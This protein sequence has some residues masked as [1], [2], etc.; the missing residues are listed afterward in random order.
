MRTSRRHRGRELALRVLFEIDG[1]DKGVGPAL[2]Y[3][4]R[5]LTSPP[6]VTAF[7]ATLANGWFEHSGTVDAA[8][9]L[10]STNWKLED[11]GKVERAILRLATYELV[12]GDTPAAVA[13][14]EAVE[15]A[16][17]YA[18][19]EASS[20]VNGVLSEVERARH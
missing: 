8:I 20:F 11:L 17:V 10:A 2:E 12:L 9:S 18:G 14:D 15:L 5:E 19:D 3:Q 1:T 4:A 7:A 16:K 6:D 13:I